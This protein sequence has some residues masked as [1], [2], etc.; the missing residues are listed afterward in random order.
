MLADSIYHIKFSDS[1]KAQA[2]LK[3]RY[4]S[5]IRVEKSLPAQ[6]IQPE[7]SPEE[8]RVRLDIKEL[9]SFLA[10]VLRKHPEKKNKEPITDAVSEETSAPLA[11]K[12][13]KEDIA[14]NETALTL[15][16]CGWSGQ[17]VNGVNLASCNYCFAR[18]G[19]WLYNS[20]DEHGM[21]FDPVTFHRS[22]CPW[23]SPE[24]QAAIN[25]FS[26]LAAWQILVALTY[27]KMYR[28]LRH[29]DSLVRMTR[30][31]DLMSIVSN[32]DTVIT[33]SRQSKD[34]LAREDK[35]REGKLSRLK[36]AFTV[37]RHSKIDPK[38]E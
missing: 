11:E 37:K 6:I 27:N 35:V 31:E 2:D 18:A 12:A 23:Q 38:T 21:R 34:D 19:L 30:P 33:G 20:T 25:S 9:A 1:E 5:L 10:P 26:G 4:D 24:S 14:P 16:L 22:H 15:A 3:V 36:R 13:A 28:D 29:R 7:T 8:T 32:D 17:V